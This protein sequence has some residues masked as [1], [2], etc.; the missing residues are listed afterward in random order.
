MQLIFGKENA[1]KLREKYIVLDLENIKVQD[2]I[3]EVYCLVSGEKINFLDLPQLDQWI[4]LHNDFLQGFNTKQYSYC[5]EALEHLIG[6]FGGEVDSFYE[7]ILRRI[8][9]EENIK[10]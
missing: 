9:E 4:K 3:L 5:K 2:Q 7:E 1:E 6:K 10:I 8:N